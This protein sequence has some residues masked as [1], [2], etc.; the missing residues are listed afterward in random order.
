AAWRISFRCARC[1]YARSSPRPLLHWLLLGFDV[2]AVCRRRN[3]CAVDRGVG[4]A[5][6]VGE[7]V[8]VREM[9]LAHCRLRF[10]RGRCLV[11]ASYL[12]DCAAP[13]RSREAG[14]IASGKRRH[15]CYCGVPNLAHRQ[16]QISISLLDN[17]V[18][19]RSRIAAE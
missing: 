4:G 5:G 16:Q 17:E 15:T 12:V 1:A 3:E 9:D 13:N 10:H 2:A 7:S 8:A 18:V 14:A 11:A 6:F 19:P